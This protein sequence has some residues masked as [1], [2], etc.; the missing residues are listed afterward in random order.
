MRARNVRGVRAGR[1]RGADNCGRMRLLCASFEL[2]IIQKDADNDRRPSG[3]PRG[4][5]CRKACGG[6]GG[7]ETLHYKIYY[8][9]IVR[10][11]ERAGARATV[12]ACVRACLRHYATRPIAAIA[13]G[14]GRSHTRVMTPRLVRSGL[15]SRGETLIDYGDGNDGQRVATPPVD[16]AYARPG[17]VYIYVIQ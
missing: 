3:P 1:A 14:R 6:G 8:Y 5:P 15:A 13:C 11:H 2:F 12:R 17:G 4:Q 16:G 10:T 7:G 9:I